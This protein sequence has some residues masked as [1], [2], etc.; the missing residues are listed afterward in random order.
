M[1]DI[2]EKEIVY[3]NDIIDY[4]QETIN[5][6]VLLSKIKDCKKNRKKLII[7]CKERYRVLYE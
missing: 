1:I 4:M 7:K 5:G 2:K 3:T 6:L